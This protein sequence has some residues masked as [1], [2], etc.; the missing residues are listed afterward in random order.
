MK[1]P[2]CVVSE[3]K[4]S[5][6]MGVKIIVFPTKMCAEG[7]MIDNVCLSVDTASAQ[8][9]AGILNT[10]F[11]E[12]VI[13]DEP[14][15]EVFESASGVKIIAFPIEIRTDYVSDD[16][17]IVVNADFA[18]NIAQNIAEVLNKRYEYLKGL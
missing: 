12:T 6:E 18:Q 7:Y 15:C 3:T 9:I 2:F 11:K 13:K 14:F 4:A 17:C 8:N 10:K 1:L 5:L 16:V